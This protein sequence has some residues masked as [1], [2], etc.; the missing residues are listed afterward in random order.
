MSFCSDNFPDDLS[1]PNE[2]N[3]LRRIPPNHFYFDENENRIRPSSA[4]FEDDEDDHPMS[5]YLSGVLLRENREPSSVLV[6]HEGYALAAITAGLA[7]E[8]NQTIHPDPLPDESSHAAVCGDKGRSQ[9][10]AP[11]KQFALM[12]VWIVGPPLGTPK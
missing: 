3:L 11:R 6:G 8:K 5:V 9:K 7:R 2:S 12:A 1:I 4:A 10:T